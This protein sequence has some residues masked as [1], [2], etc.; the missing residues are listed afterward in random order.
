[1]IAFILSG[2]S[3]ISIYQKSTDYFQ[4]IIIFRQKHKEVKLLEGLKKS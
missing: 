1:M 4:N 3:Y 2:L